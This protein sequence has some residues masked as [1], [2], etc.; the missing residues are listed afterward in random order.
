EKGCGR[1][2]LDDP[3]AA[4]DVQSRSKSPVG[5]PRVI[6]TQ[7]S[8]AAR[9]SAVEGD[10]VLEAPGVHLQDLEIVLLRH[11]GVGDRVVE[12]PQKIDR[13]G[14][15]IGAGIDDPGAA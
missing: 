10:L 5:E 6:E 4:L 14:S 3:L 1:D 11:G 15:D 7:L 9:D 12:S 2:A 13:R 8:V